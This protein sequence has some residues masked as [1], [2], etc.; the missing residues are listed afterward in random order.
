M[1]SLFEKLAAAML[2]VALCEP[3]MASNGINPE[4][5]YMLNTLLILVC[6]VLAMFMAAGFA[7]LEAG[8]VR[9]KSVATILAKNVS[10]YAVASLMYFVVG[11]NLMYGESVLGLFGEFAPFIFREGGGAAIDTS[12][13]SGR[14][15]TQYALVGQW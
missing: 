14:T 3:A 13:K 11:F 10:L 5:A 1:K 2:I 9:S 7:M 8:M 6:G 4:V 15:S 12:C